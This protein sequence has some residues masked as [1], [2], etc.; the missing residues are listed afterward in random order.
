MSRKGLH[1]VIVGEGRGHA[2]TRVQQPMDILKG[3]LGNHFQRPTFRTATPF[4]G[5]QCLF[6]WSM[7]QIVEA[8]SDDHAL[9]LTVYLSV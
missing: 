9:R 2:F 7:V 8:A 6:H 4:K 1:P 5:R 3:P